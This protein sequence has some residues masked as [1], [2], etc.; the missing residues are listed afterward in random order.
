MEEVSFHMTR[1]ER[2]ALSEPKAKRT[3]EKKK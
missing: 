3:D 2:Q 1:A